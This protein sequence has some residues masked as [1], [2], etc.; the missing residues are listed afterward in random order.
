MFS[1]HVALFLALA[2][3]PD[4]REAR[5][6]DEVMKIG[7]ELQRAI[8]KHDVQGILRYVARDGMTCGDGT[9]SKEEVRDDLETPGTRAYAYLF[10]AATF[11][12]RYRTYDDVDMDTKSIAEVLAAPGDAPMKVNFPTHGTGKKDLNSPCLVFGIGGSLE[13][14]GAP[15]L[16]FRPHKGKGPQ[17]V[18]EGGLYEC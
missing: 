6:I 13:R 2:A 15:V 11:N 8:R 1:T 7:A 3:P 14:G 12:A 18:L 4:D 17:W 16:C 10:D 5:T 9:M